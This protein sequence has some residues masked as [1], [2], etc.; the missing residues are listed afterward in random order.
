M[1]RFNPPLDDGEILAAFPGVYSRAASVYAGGQG[2]VF[3][4][5]RLDGSVG[6]LKIYVPDAAAQVEERTAREVEALEHIARPTIVTLD[7]HG[8]VTIRGDQCRYVCTTF[9]DG[10]TLASRATT[11]GIG[12]PL[13]Q[14]ARIGHDIADAVEALWAR[15]Y[16][17]VHR[18]IKPQ[19]IMLSTSGNAVLID[20]GIARHT[21]LESLTLTGG[22]WG[23]PGFMSPE[24]ATARKAFDLPPVIRPA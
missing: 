14:V 13:E 4:A 20:L 2:A 17:I 10:V 8:T 23:T 24:Q 12:M 16:R 9:I 3:R 5:E 11:P 22:A 7:G 15:P 21:T 6:A 19:N 18:D 1:P